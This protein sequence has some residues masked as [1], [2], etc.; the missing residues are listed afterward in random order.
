VDVFALTMRLKE[1]G[2]AQVKASVDRLGQSFDDSQAKAKGYDLSLK[3]LKS[4]FSSLATAFAAKQVFQ[5][6]IDETSTAQFA[7]AQLAAALKSTGNVAGQSVAGLN[8]MAAALQDTTV[9]ADDAVTASQSLLLTFT[10]VGSDTFPRAT[11]AIADVAQA[12]GTDLKSATIQVGK[13]LND[14]IQG[15]NALARSGIQFTAA[16]KQMIATMVETNRIADAQRIILQE[17]ETQFGGSAEEAG[18]TLGGAIARLNNAFGDLFEV[19]TGASEGVVASID[20]IIKGLKIL[21]GAIRSTSQA[22]QLAG[23]YAGIAFAK[24]TEFFTMKPSDY[25]SFLKTLALYQEE[26]ENVILGLTREE[27]ATRK[28]AAAIDATTK[29]LKSQLELTIE[30]AALRPITFAEVGRLN[31]AEATLVDRLKDKNMTLAAEVALQKE[32]KVIQEARNK[33]TVTGTD[34]ELSAMMRRMAAPAGAPIQAVR[35]PGQVTA[36]DPGTIAKV[37]AQ[38]AQVAAEAEQAAADITARLQ[39]SFAG[40][41]VGTFADALAAGFEAAIASGKISEGFKAFGSVLLSGLG[42]MLQQFGTAALLA[43][44]L[45]IKL[46]ASMASMNP[47]TGIAASLALIALGGALKGAARSAFGGGG[48][49]GVGG[50]GGGYSAPALASTMTMPAAFYG[51][52][53]AGSAN[54]IERINP[55]AVTIIGPNDP[56]AQRQMQELIRNADRRGNV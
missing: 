9:F 14:P 4:A 5:K 53:A 30:L 24:L 52:T 2:A 34:R 55:I 12:M 16:Q 54:T 33:A 29:E 15:V 38:M 36:I 56:T 22:I 47:A 44:K 46:M 19:S 27:T 50:G 39:Q 13:A 28:V 7:Q 31:V 18:K 37:R 20:F 23:L 11:R 41:I 45:M 26:Q 25:K 40:A 1:E 32:L 3:S 51:P 8:E 21:D 17:L 35:G 43:N 48:A 49:G 6:L 10:Q 42:G